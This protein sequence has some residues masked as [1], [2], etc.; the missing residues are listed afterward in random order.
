MTR[1][2]S[3]DSLFF[4]SGRQQISQSRIWTTMGS[5]HGQ[6]SNK[7][8]LFFNNFK[9]A[10]NLAREASGTLRSLLGSPR[11]RKKKVQG[12]PKGSK[13]PLGNFFKFLLNMFFP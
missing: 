5:P 11:G 4:A 9:I 2:S 7:N 10:L 13:D 1:S 6:K 12:A 3:F 8:K